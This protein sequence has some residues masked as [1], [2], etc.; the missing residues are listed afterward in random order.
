MT[1]L[2]RNINI[3]KNVYKHDMSWMIRGES[4][5]IRDSRENT[6]EPVYEHYRLRQFEG[7]TRSKLVSILLSVILSLSVLSSIA[8]LQYDEYVAYINKRIG[9]I[10][11]TKAFCQRL[12]FTNIDTIST[13]IAGLLVI[14]YVLIYKRRVFLR[15]EFRYRN[16][17]LPMMV[18][19]WNKSDRLFSAFTYGLIAFNV[20]GIVKSSIDGSNNLI[21]IWNVNDPTGLL[22]LLYKIVQMFLVGIRYY[23]VLVGE[24]RK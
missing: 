18:S 10:N 22:D 9:Y 5:L 11:E 17:G 13:P 8:L 15:N 1:K 16:V 14:L 24:L 2:I 23:P 12:I 7:K 20:F 21:S 6:S 4:Y 3:G 19:C